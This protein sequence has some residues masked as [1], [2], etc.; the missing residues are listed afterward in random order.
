M[1]RIEIDKSCK[2]VDQEREKKINF[3]IEM[4]KEHKISNAKIFCRDENLLK[5]I[6]KVLPRIIVL[7]PDPLEF[8]RLAKELNIKPKEKNFSD[9]FITCIQRSFSYKE[10]EIVNLGIH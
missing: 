8:E 4:L 5:K 9:G 2:D 3:V 10:I 1:E 7:I 6:K